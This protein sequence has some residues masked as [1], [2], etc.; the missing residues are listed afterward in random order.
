[1]S[2]SID[3]V[4][5]GRDTVAA[6][7]YA[8]RNAKLLASLDKEEAAIKEPAIAPPPN[9]PTAPNTSLE[10][11]T[12]HTKPALVEALGLQESNET[13]EIILNFTTSNNSPATFSV[14]VRPIATNITE[15]CVTL[16]IDSSV[17][18]KPPTLLPL[19]VKKSGVTYPVVYAGTILQTPKLN[20]LSFLRTT[21]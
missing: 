6:Q 9:T 21:V 10:Q 3:S 17:N 15:D 14:A 18:V 12:H 8:A 11:T 20:V 5:T 7:N 13:I 2:K 16:L 4:D 1:M 19:F